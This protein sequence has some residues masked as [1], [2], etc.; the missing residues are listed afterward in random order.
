MATAKEKSTC[1]HCGEVF[2][3][4]RST[5]RGKTGIF[6]SRDC[7][8]KHKTSS[9]NK[10]IIKYSKC[11]KCNK[12]IRQWR[13]YCSAEC[14]Y[15]HQDVSARLPIPK[16]GSENPAWKGG[17]TPQTVIDRNKFSKQVSN[18]VFRRDNYTCQ[19]CGAKGVSLHADHLDK[20]SVNKDDRFNV[21]NCRSLCRPCHY[22]VTFGN[23]MPTDSKWGISN[24]SKKATCQLH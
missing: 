7:Y 20:W 4:Y 21:D 18:L 3:Y 17:I 16:F 15:K 14:Y 13:K 5:L 22:F 19:L 1:K 11:A 23:S 9:W 12:Q 24:F 2:L 6:C 10:G 8:H